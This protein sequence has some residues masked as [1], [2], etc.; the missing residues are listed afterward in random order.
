M[1]GGLPHVIV[2]TS[3]EQTSR[4]LTG[5]AQQQDN[6][7]AYQHADGLGSIR[8]LSD[9]SAEVTRL[10]SYDP[11]G[12]LNQQS[13]PGAS[14][15]GYTGEQE[16]ANTGLV[17]L[18]ARFYDPGVGRFVSKDPWSGSMLRP[19]TQNGWAYVSNN[20]INQTDPSGLCEGPTD[21]ECW[22][23][24]RRL[25]QKFPH[26][27]DYFEG[28]YGAKLY[29]LPK[30][31]LE[32][33]L[34]RPSGETIA[35]GS[36]NNVLALIRLFEAGHLPGDTARDR[37]QWIL[38]KTASPPGTFIQFGSLFPPGD[39]GFCDEL[40]DGKYYA[41]PG[42]PPHYTPTDIWHTA[43]RGDPSEQ[44]GHFLTAVALGFNPEGAFYQTYVIDVVE[45]FVTVGI[46]SKLAAIPEEHALNLIVGHE[47]IG[48]GKGIGQVPAIPVQYAIATEEARSGF[49]KA[50]EHDR[51]GNDD[52]RDQVLR[53]I[54]IGT[55]S[56]FRTQNAVAGATRVGNSM[57]D[58]RNSVKGWR[59]G[60][61]IGNGTIETRQGAADWLR[62]EIYDPSRS[63]SRSY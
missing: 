23:V 46:E 44:I 15:F 59:F 50:V 42:L 17:F 57:E 10:Q 2:E 48:D 62:E 26:L 14:G 18:R 4:Y 35:Q 40:A 31:V 36:P 11:F 19:Q 49:L 13:G 21:W 33:A 55:N 51:L 30:D 60:Q 58:F 39:S 29:T 53:E 27:P 61:E 34:N 12:T 9:A 7:W 5:L 47:M 1:A 52:L 37:L 43:N 6:V 20:P 56:E 54:L 16:D 32:R 25:V 3:D 24:Y 28:K 22:A 63:R 41:Q 38:A 45:E 8:H